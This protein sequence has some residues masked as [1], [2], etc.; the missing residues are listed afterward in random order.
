MRCAHCEHGFN[1]K[2]FRL[3]RVQPSFPQL[4]LLLEFAETKGHNDEGD[5]DNKS[6]VT[7]AA[8]A[9]NYVPDTSTDVGSRCC[10]RQPSDFH[11]LKLISPMLILMGSSQDSS[12]WFFSHCCLHR[13]QGGSSL[14]LVPPGSF[15]GS[16]DMMTT[17]LDQRLAG[18]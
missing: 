14:S 6:G 10:R 1:S 16:I 5:S 12:E 8:A 17:P 9:G 2:E 3:A 15:T 4:G 18:F 11:V 13:R 7:C